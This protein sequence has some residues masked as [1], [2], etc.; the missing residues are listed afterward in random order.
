MCSFETVYGSRVN[1]NVIAC[2][3]CLFLYVRGCE[4]FRWV[5]GDTIF[6]GCFL[7][8]DEVAEDASRAS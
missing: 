6:D 1:E 8:L 4:I 3:Y 2:F 7:G 5:S